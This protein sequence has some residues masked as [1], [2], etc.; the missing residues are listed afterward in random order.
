MKPAPFEYHVPRTL[1]EALTLLAELGDDAMAL[2]G[3]QSL[4]PMLNLRLAYAEHLIDLNRIG[5]LAYIRD[6]DQV[7]A[8]GAMT[9]HEV[10][11]AS[12]QVRVSAPLMAEALPHVAYPAIRSRGTVGGSIANADP[13]AEL[14]CVLV[15]AGG[16][17]VLAST[18]GRREVA[19]ED[20]F[21]GPYT[22]SRRPEELVV[23]VRLPEPSPGATTAF[24]EVSRSA[25]EFALT[26]VGVT[27]EHE[28]DRC[29][30]ATIAVAGATGASTRARSAEQALVGAELT[31][32]AL[33]SAAQLVKDDIEPLGDGH[34]SADY[35][36]RVTGVAA[37]R[38]LTRAAGQAM[39]VLA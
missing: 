7:L 30:R 24:E 2:A 33:A 35:R 38:A 17:V 23:E 20:F 8:V 14:P 16:T 18:S 4:V 1:D 31:P 12:E 13:K 5:E 27:L 19:S 39:A 22:T 9:R 37:K 34:G 3:G 32:E 11:L 26:L 36:R 28:D 15:A 21:I 10:A 25:G 6:E 29:T